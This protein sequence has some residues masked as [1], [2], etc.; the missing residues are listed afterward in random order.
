MDIKKIV[1]P[2]EIP[3]ESQRIEFYKMIN[4]RNNLEI[5]QLMAKFASF[6]SINPANNKFKNTTQNITNALKKIDTND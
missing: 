2:Q 5:N 1:I 3:K 6:N 4:S